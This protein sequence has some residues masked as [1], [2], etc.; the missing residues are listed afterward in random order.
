MSSIDEQVDARLQALELRVGLAATTENKAAKSDNDIATRLDVL[1]QKWKSSTVATF[2]QICD[3]SDKLLND[4]HPGPGL[5]YQQVLSG[6]S[7]DY[8]MLYRKQIV[9]A[10][11]D[12]L[13][14]DMSHLSNILNLLYISQ[15]SP[16]KDV[17]QAPILS[18]PPV[19]P[20]EEKRLDLLRVTAAD[21]HVQVAELADRM[22]SLITTYQQA[23]IA[24]SDRMIR[25]EEKIAQQG[26]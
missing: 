14:Q 9:L 13:R 16:L 24:L 8:P 21:C 17:T 26:K 6:R 22:D 4:L 19:S 3:A 11:Q 10:S 15:K 1:E 2:N 25:V 18:T 5:T 20:E 7:Q 23:M 12:T